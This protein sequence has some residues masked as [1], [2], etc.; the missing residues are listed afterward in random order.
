[1]ILIIFIILVLISTSIYTIILP[2]PNTYFEPI[3]SSLKNITT[4]NDN[5]IVNF[6]NG[7]EGTLSIFIYLDPTQRTPTFGTNNNIVNFNIFSLG[8]PQNS[9]LSFNQYPGSSSGVNT[10]EISI[11]T[12]K[13]A[14]TTSTARNVEKISLQAIPLQEWVCVT[15]ARVGRRYTVFYNNKIISSFRTTYYPVIETSAAWNIGDIKSSGY[16][17][18]AMASTNAFILSDVEEQISSVADSRN[19]PILP[20]PTVTSAFNIFS[21][22][23][24]CPDGIFCYTASYAPSSGINLWSSPFA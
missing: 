12:A 4:F 17:A 20:N 24:G 7:S 5:K 21:L 23:G 2:N 1:M 8:S 3:S 16:Y 14:M 15:I 11:T 19:K 18:Y 9:I 10:A 6:I 22:F 13:E